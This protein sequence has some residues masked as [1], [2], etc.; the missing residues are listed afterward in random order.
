[1]TIGTIEDLVE[2]LEAIRA[3]IHPRRLSNEQYEA[4]GWA[5]RPLRALIDQAREEAEMQSWQVKRVT[6]YSRA[7]LPG[8]PIGPLLR[9]LRK[10][11]P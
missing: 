1:M 8:S 7:V 6:D 10:C 3:E 5:D 9:P 11:G 4:V 2:Q